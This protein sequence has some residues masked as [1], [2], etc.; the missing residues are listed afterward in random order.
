MRGENYLKG[1]TQRFAKTQ[2]G[3]EFGVSPTDSDVSW[4]STI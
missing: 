1:V 2:K 4:R 3:I